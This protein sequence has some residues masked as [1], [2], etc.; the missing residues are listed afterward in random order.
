VTATSMGRRRGAAPRASVPARLLVVLLAVVASVAVAGPASAHVGGGVAGS[1]FTG[2]VLSVSPRLP[3]V[4]VR[5]LQFGDDVELRNRTSTEVVVPGYSDEPYLRIG[6]RG[7]FRNERSP[8]TYINLDR[9]ARVKLPADADP[10]AAPR[11]R[12]VA[13]GSAYV[14]HDHRTHW[15]TQT[16]LPPSVAADPSVSH[17]VF[18]WTVPLRYGG[19]P[20]TVRGVLR[21]DPP[22]AAGL[23]WPVYAG[24]FLL[25]LLAGL[26]ARGPRPLAGVLLVAAAAALWDAG[27]T[28]APAATQGSH[29]GAVIAALLPALLTVVVA[30]IGL[31]AAL[32]D[33]GVLT[34]LMAVAVGWLTLIQGLPDV[35]ALWSAHVLSSGPEWGARGAVALMVALGGG[36]V[37]GGIA[38]ARRFRATAVP[39]PDAREAGSDPQPEPAPAP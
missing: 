29:A 4:T 35:D 18:R 39:T 9:Y 27:A 17:T 14:W 36:C 8:A 31:R 38:A 25:A 2:R 3:G 30:C 16:A 26:L 20:V 21:W 28:P 32:R 19:T 15:M 5:V 12:Q 23:V 13:T 10:K 24:L 1:D 7:V 34:G 22:P 37:L 6:P 33:R 11:W